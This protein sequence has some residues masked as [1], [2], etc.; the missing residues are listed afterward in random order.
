MNRKSINYPAILHCCTSVSINR[1]RERKRS[2][3]IKEVVGGG[4]GN[5]RSGMNVSIFWF[6]HNLPTWQLPGIHPATHDWTPEFLSF[7]NSARGYWLELPI[8]RIY[9]MIVHLSTQIS[10]FAVRLLDG[11]QPK[12]IIGDVRCWFNL[13]SSGMGRRESNAMHVAT[14]LNSYTKRRLGNRN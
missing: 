14:S 4:G 13:T 12:D 7:P 2:W 6:V 8:H 11:G 1:W 5:G 9:Y 3:P 10:P